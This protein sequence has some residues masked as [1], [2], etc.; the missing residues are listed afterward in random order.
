VGRNSHADQPV[1]KASLRVPLKG[2][3]EG[4][5]EL[6]RFIPIPT[7]SRFVF[8]AQLI[9]PGLRKARPVAQRTTSA[10]ARAHGRSQAVSSEVCVATYL[11]SERPPQRTVGLA[12]LHLRKDSVRCQ[13]SFG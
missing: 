8:L 11:H 10:T 4:T 1:L 7:S 3:A 13:A 9:A 12:A 5:T 2:L 6:R